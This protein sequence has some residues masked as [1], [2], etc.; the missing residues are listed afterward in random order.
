VKG[1][2]IK[3]GGAGLRACQ[4]YKLRVDHG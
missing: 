3:H 4:P 1:K 2:S